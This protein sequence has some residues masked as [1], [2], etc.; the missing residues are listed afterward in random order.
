MPP[1]I[2]DERGRFVPVV[3]P[4]LWQTSTVRRSRDRTDQIGHARKQSKARL[5]TTLWLSVLGRRG[6][7]EL[8]AYGIEWFAVETW[9]D[10]LNPQESNAARRFVKGVLDAL[11]DPAMP[12]RAR[13]AAYNELYQRLIGAGIV[14]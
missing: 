2:R 6:I 7:I 11:A 3:R 8:E 13:D 14:D 1:I 10:A 9:L 4:K 12:P 5:A